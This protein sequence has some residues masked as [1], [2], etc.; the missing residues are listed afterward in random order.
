MNHLL[1][2]LP[3]HLLLVLLFLHLLLEPL[4]LDLLVGLPSLFLLLIFTIEACA[5]RKVPSLFWVLVENGLS[6]SFHFQF[7]YYFDLKLVLFS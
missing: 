5:T 4:P 3:F 1:V 6:C 2:H 7:M